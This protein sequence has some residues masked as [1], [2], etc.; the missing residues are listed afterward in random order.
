MFPWQPLRET[1]VRNAN[2]VLAQA[3]EAALTIHIQETKA[4]VHVHTPWMH[5]R[6]GYTSLDVETHGPKLRRAKRST[7]SMS[8]DDTS[9]LI[10]ICFGQRLA[11]LEISTLRNMRMVFRF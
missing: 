11:A 2:I 6:A 8:C 5:A 1:G 10:A 7:A 3:R 9:F 4:M